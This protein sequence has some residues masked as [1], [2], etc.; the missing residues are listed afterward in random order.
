MSLTAVRAPVSVTSVLTKLIAI[1]SRERLND[2][3]MARR[4]G[5]SRPHWNLVRH[6]RRPL[7][8]AVALRAAGAFP[9]L[10]RDLI[11]LAADSVNTPAHTATEVQ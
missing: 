3:A 5:L 6:G 1:Q 8:H 7:T 4:I 9:E 10:T 2:A 11:D